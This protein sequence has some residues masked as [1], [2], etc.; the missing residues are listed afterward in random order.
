MWGANYNFKS[1]T[2]TNIG[3]CVTARDGAE[4]S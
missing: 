3:E 4:M 1:F 2:S